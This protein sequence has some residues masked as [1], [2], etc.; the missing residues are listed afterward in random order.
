VLTVA[1]LVDSMIFSGAKRLKGRMDDGFAGPG[2]KI[3]CPSLP[4]RLIHVRL[5]PLFKRYRKV[6]DEQM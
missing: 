5:E 3:V 6:D 4:C 2:G 1:G